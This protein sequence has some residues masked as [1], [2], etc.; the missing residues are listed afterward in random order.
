MLSDPL[1]R[2]SA[3]LK[4]ADEMST[5][6]DVPPGFPLWVE[7]CVTENDCVWRDYHADLKAKRQ[8]E[9]TSRVAIAEYEAWRRTPGARA[10]SLQGAELP[11]EMLTPA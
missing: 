9:R 3:E 4:M 6:A 11:T 2:R 10:V 8:K 7:A 1:L 5:Q